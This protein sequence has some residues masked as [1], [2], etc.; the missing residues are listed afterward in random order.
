MNT[1]TLVKLLNAGQ[2]E[3]FIRHIRFPH[4]KNLVPFTRIEFNF[5]ITALVGANGTNK[6]SIL[7]ALYGAP[8]NNNLGNFWFSTATDPIQEG[9]GKRNCFVYGYQHSITSDKIEVLKT[10]SQ[11]AGNPDYWEPSRPLKKYDMAPMPEFDSKDPNRVQTR[12]NPISKNV[13]LIDFR[14][15]LS[16]FDQYFYFGEFLR[17]KSFRTKQDFIRS[18]APHLSS[19]INEPVDEYMFYKKNRIIKKSIT[20]SNAE[21]AAICSILDREYEEIKVIEH[22]FFNQSGY[23]AQLKQ[24][25]IRYTEAFAGSGEFAAIRIVSAVLNAPEKSLILL[26]EP[27]VSLHPG[28]Q[29]KL[30]DFLA[31]QVILKKHQIIFTTHSPTL[32][33]GLPPQAIK[34]LAL[35]P[36]FQVY[37]PS[38]ESLPS[39]AFL[40]I[41]EPIKDV[42]KIIVEDRLA[43]EIVKKTL[44]E[45]NKSLLKILSTG[46][47]PGGASALFMLH[48]P[49]YAAEDRKNLLCLLDGDQRLMPSWP[50]PNEVDLILKEDLADTIKKLT[51]SDIQFQIDSGSKEKQDYQL[52]KLRRQYLKWCQKYVKYFPGTLSPEALIL[53]ELE[54]CSSAVDSK[55]SFAKL[56]KDDLGL[57]SD[58]EPSSDDI[59]Q[60]Q[61]RY[62]ASIAKESENL[63]QI[64]QEIDGFV[65][66]AQNE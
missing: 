44:R 43:E 11:R 26:D 50:S 39:E 66:G 40:H 1:N 64:F 14:H 18:R 2:L 30:L 9:D 52:E 63:K 13:V 31:D 53:S 37:L 46:F 33:N 49:I 21:L 25:N 47:F 51:G 55:V 22:S 20:L 45:W 5:P 34:V 54:L 17:S 7:R 61:R 23:T 60:T 29:N 48:I 32:I 62:L 4:Y 19:A 8:D 59:F 3:P 12:W 16:A 15:S 41:G 35:S 58:E 27:E 10:R 24:S 6:S 42:K 38:Q 57:L 28:A 65:Q 56:T 36:N